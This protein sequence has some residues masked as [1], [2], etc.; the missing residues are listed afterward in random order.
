MQDEIMDCNVRESRKVHWNGFR[1]QTHS[2]KKLGFSPK[3]SWKIP[4][5]V[6]VVCLFVFFNELQ[7]DTVNVDPGW[8]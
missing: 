7:N 6:L 1:F 3:V 5:G 4:V 2:F 8:N